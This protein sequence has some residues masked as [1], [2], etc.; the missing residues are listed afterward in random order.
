MASLEAIQRKQQLFKLN[1][2]SYS[3]LIKEGIEK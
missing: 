1:M 3:I 2:V